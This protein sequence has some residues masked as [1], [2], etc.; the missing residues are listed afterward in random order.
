MFPYFTLLLKCLVFMFVHSIEKLLYLYIFFEFSIQKI[1]SIQ[2][3]NLLI[4]SVK[5]RVRPIVFS[6][7]S[8]LES[9]IF[10]FGKDECGFDWKIGLTQFCYFQ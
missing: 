8:C 4:L 1:Q 10:V 9:K 3:T 6:S 5:N 2:R 7:T